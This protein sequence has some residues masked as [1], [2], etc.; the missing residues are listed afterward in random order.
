MATLAGFA[1][2][3]HLL[4]L[5]GLFPGPR[6]HPG[7]RPQLLPGLPD[8]QLGTSESKA[9]CP[10]CRQTFAPRSILP[11]RQLA[12]VLEVARRCEGPLGEEEGGFCP[13][14]QEPLNH[15]CR[16]HETLTC[17]VCDRSKDH[18]GHSVIPA[19][20]AFQEYQVGIS[21]E[22]SLQGDSQILGL[23]GDP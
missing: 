3:S 18:K 9:S 10:K 6:A 20:E 21:Q 12:R 16:E 1:G 22:E 15:F 17:V 5:P 7:V 11:N 2:R 19:E 23:P 14:H 13:K 8:P 4:H